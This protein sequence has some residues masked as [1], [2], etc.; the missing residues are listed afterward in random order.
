MFLLGFLLG[1]TFSIAFLVGEHLFAQLDRRKFSN[2]A[3]SI[4]MTPI[5]ATTATLRRRAW[6]EH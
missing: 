5:S 4:F 6:R 2:L 3:I 1:V